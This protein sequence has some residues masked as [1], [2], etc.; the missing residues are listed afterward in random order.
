MDNFVHGGGFV[1]PVVVR[2][3]AIATGVLRDTMEVPAR[4]AVSAPVVAVV[5]TP[6]LVEAGMVVSG[7]RVPG[8]MVLRAVALGALSGYG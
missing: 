6:A 5:A 2:V 3:A 1:A 4:L 8:A 7:R